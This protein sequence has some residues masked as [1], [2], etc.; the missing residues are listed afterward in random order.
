MMIV[1]PIV[2]LID[3]IRPALGLLCNVDVMTV[4]HSLANARMDQKSR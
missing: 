3:W 1:A 2:M 4:G